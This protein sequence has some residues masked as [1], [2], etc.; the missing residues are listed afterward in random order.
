MF[1]P[2]MFQPQQPAQPLMQQQSMQPMQQP[3]FA[4]LSSQ[5]LVSS[6]SVVTPDQMHCHLTDFAQT[7]TPSANGVKATFLP[8]RME[9]GMNARDGINWVDVHYRI[10]NGDQ[11]NARMQR[12]SSGGDGSAN[13]AA[14]AWELDGIP[15]RAGADDI[16]YF[17]TYSVGGSAQK[18][19][20][21]CDTPIF[22]NV[23]DDSADSTEDEHTHT[24]GPTATAAPAQA[25][26]PAPTAAS[27]AA[28]GR[29]R[30]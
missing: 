15:M 10:N 4:P 3:R 21:S 16:A 24:H 5:P 20:P 27:N 25:S 7:L 8:N 2:S 30:R 29:R 14:A 22:T 26:P 19:G 28:A 1:Q 6:S 23:P 12:S 18:E 13:T 9:G 11:I 17:F